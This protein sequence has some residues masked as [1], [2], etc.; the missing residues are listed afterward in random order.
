[1]LDKMK[2]II[3]DYVDIDAAEIN[4]STS[5][6]TDL[7]LTSLALMNILV[8]L[9]DEFDIEIDEDAAVEFVTVGDVIQH[10]KGLGIE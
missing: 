3:S 5:L 8:A 7:G 6:K 1:M 2:N 9:E 4:E 10:L